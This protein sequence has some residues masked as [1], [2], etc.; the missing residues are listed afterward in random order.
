MQF[1]NKI[2]FNYNLKLLEDYFGNKEYQKASELLLEI[3]KKQPDTFFEL[4]IAIDDKLIDPSNKEFFQKKILWVTSFDLS[5]ANYINSFLNFYLEKNK[6]I[7]FIQGDYV[8]LL[9]ASLSKLNSKKIPENIKFEEIINSSNFFQNLLLLDSNYNFQLLSQCASFFEANQKKYLIYPN[10]TACYFYIYR[11]PL[12]LFAK[13]KKDLGSSQAAL[14]ELF[15]YT[16]EMFLNT[17]IQNHNYKIYEHRKDWNT[18]VKSWSDDNVISTYRGMCINY[19]KLITE[20]EE[21]LTNVIYHI[22]QSGIEIDFE[23]DFISEFIKNNP[24][25]TED[26]ISCSNNEKKALRNN[27]DKELIN[28]LD[29]SI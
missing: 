14:Q 6:S 29:Y 9:E 26:D 22:K 16:D 20:T 25:K 15:N 24:L 4:L 27:L 7:S 28:Q 3:K 21:V 23:F 1:L 10:T 17:K 8:E 5:D 13:Y 2:K 11:N 12:D 19:E 18:N